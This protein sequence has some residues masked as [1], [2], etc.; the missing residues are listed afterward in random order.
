[1]EGNVRSDYELVSRAIA[2]IED[3]SDEQPDL[4]AIADHVGLS[5]YHFQRLFKRWV[6]ISP[7]RFLQLI[8]LQ[9]AKEA[10]EHDQSVLSASYE[11]GLSSP[12]RLHDLFVT[13]D[14]VTP[15]EFKAKGNGV[16]IRTGVHDSPFG[17]CLIAATD[18]GVCGLSFH[19]CAACEAGL[20]LQRELWP[21]ADFT[22]DKSFTAPL[23]DRVFGSGEE[24]PSPFPLRIHGTNFQVKVWQA[25]LGIPQGSLS[26]YGAVARRIGQPK[27]SR[28][29]GTAVGRNPVSYLIPCHRVITSTGAYGNYRW[30]RLRKTAMIGWELAQLEASGGRRFR[31]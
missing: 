16:A 19:D 1:L 5:P 13:I 20:A 11:A 31:N 25:L 21:L 29:V 2:F 15:G 10:L 8:T 18:R 24:V 14:A 27:A 22:S 6:G 17:Y 12:G 9:R 26:T 4:G 28:A 7:K 3:N 30:G 23:A